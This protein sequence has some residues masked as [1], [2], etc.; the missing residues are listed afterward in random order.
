MR[1]CKQ[2]RGLRKTEK[3]ANPTSEDQAAPPELWF[4][5]LDHN[6]EDKASQSEVSGTHAHFTLVVFLS[7]ALTVMLRS[8]TKTKQTAVL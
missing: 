6:S 5:D 4:G 7:H 8:T 1:F 2:Q 3:T